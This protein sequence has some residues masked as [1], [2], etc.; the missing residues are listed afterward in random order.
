MFL[1]PV[2]LPMVHLGLLEDS[3]FTFFLNFFSIINPGGRGEEEMII[4]YVLRVIYPTKYLYMSLSLLYH[5]AGG[6]TKAQF[7]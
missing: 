7:K 6:D 1:H 2:S 3:S 5:F 4:E